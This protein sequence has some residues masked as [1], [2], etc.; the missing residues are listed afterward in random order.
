MLNVEKNKLYFRK[1]TGEA[2]IITGIVDYE[3]TKEICINY[4][5]GYGA[6]Q[7]F[8]KYLV[9]HHEW[10]WFVNNLESKQS[11]NK[12]TVK[13]VK[14]QK[15]M[16]ESKNNFKE[17]RSILFETLRDVKDDKIDVKKAKSIS[18]L[19]QTLINSAK[20]EVDYIKSTGNQSKS[21]MIQ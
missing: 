15:Q 20:V 12:K 18:E 7:T 4:T 13:K 14:K 17:L 8:E 16:E 5:K 9:P 19:S 6:N 1:D 3:G 10:E 2:I 21:N 11:L